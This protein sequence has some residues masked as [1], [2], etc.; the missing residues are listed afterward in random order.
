MSR[1]RVQE[2]H[3]L[4]HLVAQSDG[5][6]PE[7]DGSKELDLQVYANAAGGEDDWQTYT[8]RLYSET[9]VIVFSKVG[10]LLYGYAPHKSN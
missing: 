6:L 9:P 7:I 5:Y 8:K 1:M 2:I 3:G 10:A 4:L